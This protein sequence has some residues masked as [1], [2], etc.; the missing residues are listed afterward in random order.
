MPRQTYAEHRAALL[1]R[2]PDGVT[3]GGVSVDDIIQL[4]LQNT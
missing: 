3:P 1:R 2:Y 4:K